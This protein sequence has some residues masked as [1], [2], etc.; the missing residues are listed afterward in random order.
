[1]A[2]DS[3]VYLASCL[4]DVHLTCTYIYG[5]TLEYIK[6]QVNLTLGTIYLKACLICMFSHNRT[7]KTQYGKGVWLTVGCSVIPVICLN[8]SLL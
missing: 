7:G 8:I 3:P 4:F 1:M 2:P 5:L 6:L